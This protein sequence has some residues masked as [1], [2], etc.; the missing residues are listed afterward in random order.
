M[1]RSLFAPLRVTARELR[2]GQLVSRPRGPLFTITDVDAIAAAGVIV[3]GRDHRHGGFVEI[4]CS[5]YTSF[6]VHQ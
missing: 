4:G 1:T 5:S 2:P 6:E 3:R